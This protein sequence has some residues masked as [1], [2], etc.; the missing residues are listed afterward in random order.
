M[1]G[2]LPVYLCKAKKLR[3]SLGTFVCTFE[4]LSI[5]KTAD[6]LYFLKSKVALHLTHHHQT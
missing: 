1:H 5:N 4:D 6:V 3:I 2:V